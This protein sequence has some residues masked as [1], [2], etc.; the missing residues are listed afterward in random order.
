MSEKLLVTMNEDMLVALRRHAKQ[1]GSSKSA[2]VRI[3][4][5]SWLQMQGDNVDHFMEWG[6]KRN[7]KQVEQS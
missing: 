6:G 1:R 7:D 3:A 4:V 5:S 2:L